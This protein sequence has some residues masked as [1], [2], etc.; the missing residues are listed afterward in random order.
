MEL[1]MRLASRLFNTLS[2]PFRFLF[3]IVFLDTDGL[4]AN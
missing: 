1:V 3:R 4:D 2:W